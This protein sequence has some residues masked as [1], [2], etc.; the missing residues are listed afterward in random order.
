MAITAFQRDICRLIADSRI[1]AGE[2][3][4]AGGVALNTL[5]HAPRLSRDID[6]FHDTR[7]A[8]LATWDAD[9]KR[10]E[11]GA[12]DIDIIRERPT[13][14]E[15]VVQRN[16]QTT[17][18]QWV[19][20]SAYRFFPL[21]KHPDFG[22]TLHPFDLATNKVLALVGR[23]EV[24]DWIDIMACS[25][26]LQHLG[27]LAWAA[28]GKD[29]GYSPAMILAEAKRSSHYSA[30]EVGELAFEGEPPDAAQLARAWTVM[31]T[32]STALI[33][34]LPPQE[35]G[36]C[37]LAADGTLFR[38][39]AAAVREAYARN[40]L[41]FHEGVIRGALPSIVDARP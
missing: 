37:V 5:L 18:M 6:L 36:R 30:A 20:D 28:C 38:G 34:T 10:L 2:S 40:E 32:E 3:Y 7:E 1:D 22:L 19:C 4:V 15:A 23:L 12:Y 29:P 41:I 14:V 25:N 16:D 33:D 26:G 27:F 21:M 17:I 8:L 31:L 11:T 9:R 35:V 24:R 13:F 39:N